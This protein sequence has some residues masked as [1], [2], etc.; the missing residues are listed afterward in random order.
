VGT[1]LGAG[2]AQAR[3][4]VGI[5]SSS[6]GNG[7]S[8]SSGP[9]RAVSRQ[10]RLL[11]WRLSKENPSWGYQRIQGELLKVGIEISASSIRRVIAPKRRPGP[12]RDTWSKFMR[13]QAASIVACERP[14]RGLDL[15]I[16]EGRPPLSLA[17]ATRPIVRRDRLGGLIHEYHR[18]AA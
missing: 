15:R 8:P 1:D 4:D 16:P 13:T 9:K 11:V 14:H 7:P 5:E 18:K 17:G 12:K 2:D 6:D 3:C 10:T